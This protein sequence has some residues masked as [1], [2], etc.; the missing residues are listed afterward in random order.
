MNYEIVSLEEK[1]VVGLLVKTTNEYNKCI[2]DIGRTWGEFMQKGA[3]EAISSKINVKSIG[4]YTDYEGDFTKPYN[5][6]ACCEVSNTDN[7]PANMVVK[8]IPKGKYARFTII[9]DVQK[10]VG[11]FWSRL[12][13]M[14][15]DRKYNADFEEYQN[16]SEDMNNQEI[17][18]Y[19]AL[20]D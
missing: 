2:M 20:N 18:I 1:T 16:N 9:G 3:Y 15:L 19:I 14:P 13:E 17:H 11:E 4:L 8:T 12:W 5:F 6:V 7:I 10:A